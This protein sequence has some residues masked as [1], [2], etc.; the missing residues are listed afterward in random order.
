MN[1]KAH[2]LIGMA[3]SILVY[4][5]I[6][7]GLTDQV[8]LFD[9]PFILFLG[10]FSGLLPDIDHKQS[11][12]TRVVTLFGILTVIYISYLTT[13]RTE[14]SI[15]WFIA[16]V[17]NAILYSLAFI[18]LLTVLRPRHRGIT[19]T[20]SFAA[21]YTVLL[22]FLTDSLTIGVVGAVGYVSHLLVDGCIRLI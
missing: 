1:W 15:D 7:K 14:Y 19:H 13:G 18:G 4:L 9:I 6:L 5:V 20:L 21:V 16:L 12:I 8:G 10:G 3:S 17:S 22:Y 11:K 2:L